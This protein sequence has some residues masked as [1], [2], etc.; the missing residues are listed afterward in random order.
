M[1]E[2]IRKRH[3]TLRDVALAAGV[4]TMTVSNVLLGRVGRM[5]AQT[6]ERIESEIAR[7]DYRPNSTARGLRTAAWQSIGMLIVDDEPAFLVGSFMT[8]I[9]AGLS[10]HLSAQNHTM[11]LQGV[12]PANFSNALFVRDIRTDGICSYLSG[13]DKSRGAAIEALLQLRQPV[14]VFQETLQFPGKDFCNIR[15]DDRAGGRMLAEEVVGAGAKRLVML[16]P[17]LYWPGIAER[18][19]GVRQVVQRASGVTLRL[20]KSPGIQFEPVQQTVARDIEEHGVPDA[21]LAANDHMGIA[22]LKFLPTKGLMVPRDVL[23]TGFNAFDFL[24]YSD[25]ILTSV[26]SPAYEMGA[27]GGQE[28]LERLRTGRFAQSEVVLPVSLQRGGST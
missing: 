8:N 6:K 1:D 23:V 17:R 15:L 14:V 13:S 22:V 28:M 7:L 9:V 10:N 20:I 21:I 4:S 11:V 3:V 18:V 27:R 19:A 12:N 5:S 16:V 26:R 25:P 2:G 24:Q